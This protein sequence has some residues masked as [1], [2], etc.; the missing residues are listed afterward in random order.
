MEYKATLEETLKARFDDNT[1]VHDISMHGMASGWSGFIYSS[2]LYDF[3]ERYEDEIED[4]LYEAGFE[5]SNIVKDPKE[6]TFQE[7]REKSVWIAVELWISQRFDE[8]QQE[9][10]LI[11]A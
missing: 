5:L 9:K 3:F 4:V 7:L 11:N 10:E 2:E 8:I 1:E 6:W